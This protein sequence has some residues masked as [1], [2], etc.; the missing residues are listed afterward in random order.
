MPRTCRLT[1]CILVLSGVRLLAQSGVLVED[2]KLVSPQPQEGGW[3]GTAVSVSGDTLAVGAPHDD[4]GAGAIYVHVRS[5]GD[6]SLQA[7]LKSPEP[8]DGFGAPLALSDDDLIVG[9]AD[10][11]WVFV[12][13]GT[14]WT[15]Q[16]KLVTPQGTSPG[17]SVAI[18]GDTAIVGDLEADGE[19]G[20]AWFFL[21]TGTT[22][23][24]RAKLVADDAH[25]HDGFSSALALDGD[26]LAIGAWQADVGE[27]H[28]VGA[29]YVFVRTGLAWTQQAKLVKLSAFPGASH[30]FGLAVALS[31]GS[32]VAGESYDSFA[33]DFSG[34][35]YVY[36]REGTTWAQQAKL[37]A[38]D[39]QI[40]AWF[41]GAV[42]IDGDS[43]VVG[44]RHADQVG[45]AYVFGRTGTT[46]K[47]Q[48]KLVA[49]DGASG[50]GLGT[51]LAISGQTAVVG[52]LQVNTSAENTGAAYL[53]TLPAPPPPTW[54][55]LGSALAG[56]Q[57]L[58]EL[59]G[60]G[61]LAP[62]TPVSL[63]LLDAH[64]FS[65][66]ML[67]V[68]VESLLVPFKGG[69]LVPVPDALVP[70]F[71]LGV[72]QAGLSAFWPAGV[73]SGQ[74]IY[75]QCWTVDPTAPQQLSASNALMASVP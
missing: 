34:A 26:T 48:A 5:G 29:I 30:G 6:W 39:P 61:S 7:T 14:T 24:L 71:T 70:L 22:W 10:G 1:L 60:V 9:V 37:K 42:A 56:S 62:G 2:V 52:A 13:A 28:D 27:S 31:G 36:L 75:L 68:G 73:P 4:A 50:D 64:P 54:S 3:F 55:D 20:A 32:V 66:S 72:G 35:A 40:V 58:P 11:A 43:V 63:T 41:G 65:T 16:A 21:R 46:W 59:T 74:L 67:V 69:T 57:G 8:A 53:Y 25:A 44:S 17:D 49:S 19:A 15:P 12:R 45:A 18:Q 38:P 33:Q 47:P 23:H 51:D